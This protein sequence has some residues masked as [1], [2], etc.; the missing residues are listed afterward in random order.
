MVIRLL[1]SPSSQPVLEQFKR[2]PEARPLFHAQ[3]T[4]E[5]RRVAQTKLRR[6]LK[7]ERSRCGRAN[8]AAKRELS[9]ERIYSKGW[10]LHRCCRSLRQEVW[11]DVLA[12]FD[13]KDEKPQWLLPRHAMNIG[14]SPLF[15]RG[16]DPSLDSRHGQECPVMLNQSLEQ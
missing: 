1:L 8:H 13:P 14:C 9:R 16:R 10:G 15:D 3:A 2:S 12:N 4:K 11:R 5:E 6:L 7:E